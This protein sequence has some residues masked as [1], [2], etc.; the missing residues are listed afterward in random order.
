MQNYL[1]LMRHETQD[2]LGRFMPPLKVFGFVVAK[3]NLNKLAGLAVEHS[4]HFEGHWLPNSRVQNAPGF[5][6][7]WTLHKLR[8]GLSKAKM[9][10]YT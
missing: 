5:P 7:R 1:S 10:I 3:N 4:K 8:H 9:Q 2:S 6:A